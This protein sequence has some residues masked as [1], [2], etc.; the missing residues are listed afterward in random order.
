MCRWER[1]TDRCT[2]QGL[3]DKVKQQPTGRPSVWS[4]YAS[5]TNCA[6]AV[7]RVIGQVDAMADGCCLW[8]CRA[9]RSRT[10][11]D[12]STDAE[13]LEVSLLIFQPLSLR[14]FPR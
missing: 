10:C 13:Q 3:G 2:H 7:Y 5:S 6:D 12:V 11:T 8:G 4:N 14:L 1:G 9:M